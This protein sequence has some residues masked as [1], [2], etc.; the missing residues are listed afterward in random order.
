MKEILEIFGKLERAFKFT[1]YPCIYHLIDHMI[2]CP[3]K[4]DYP[5]SFLSPEDKR[6]NII[7]LWAPIY[8]RG[9]LPNSDSFVVVSLFWQ[10]KGLSMAAGRHCTDRPTFFHSSGV[11][12]NFGE[13]VQM[14]H[15]SIL[16]RGSVDRS[17]AVVI[18]S[19]CGQQRREEEQ[20]SHSS[21]QNIHHY[22]TNTNYIAIIPLKLINW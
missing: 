17:I 11:K 12:L 20:F 2:H 3:V 9:H 14:S 4:M 7:D 21:T 13:P 19:K 15:R 6:S 5:T 22:S 16:I 1:R 18:K 10:W 8:Q